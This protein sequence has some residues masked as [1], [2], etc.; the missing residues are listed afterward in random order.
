MVKV[1]RWLLL[2]T[3]F[4]IE[5]MNPTPDGGVDIAAVSFKPFISGRYVI[6]CKQ[7]SEPISSLP[8]LH[9]YEVISEKEAKGVLVTTSSFAPDAIQFARDKRIELIDGEY[10][11]RL[12]RE[13]SL[14]WSWYSSFGLSTLQTARLVVRSRVAGFISW[15]DPDHMA[16]PTF[17]LTAV[18]W[19]YTG[20]F[21]FA[22]KLYDVPLVVLITLGS[23]ELVVRLLEK[24][25][26]SSRPRLLSFAERMTFFAQAMSIFLPVLSLTISY[27]NPTGCSTCPL[28]N[29][30]FL[31]TFVAGAG[32]VFLVGAFEF[33]VK[34]G[35]TKRMEEL[36]KATMAI[37][38]G[39]TLG[40]YV[41]S[42][43]EGELKESPSFSGQV[44]SHLED[45][46]AWRNHMKELRVELS[47]LDPEARD[48][49]EEVIKKVKE[50]AEEIERKS[51][52]W[53]VM[54]M[55]VSL[56]AGAGVTY[57]LHFV[58]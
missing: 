39:K 9:F 27:I 35:S 18:I 37:E 54:L 45:S 28:T 25:W 40:H 44:E 56:A 3:G 43:T 6:R 32:V 30:D 50:V 52:R 51:R 11:T 2:R 26:E 23:T 4:K 17:I 48:N 38:Q 21:A 53:D 41:P 15:L 14:L 16:L 7:E 1:V 31:W 46:E 22:S 5:G 34:K 20:L 12:M 10:L 36:R 58:V 13:K 42:I 55:G 19:Y 47:R 8:L 49:S 24:T 33:W 29:T 57:L